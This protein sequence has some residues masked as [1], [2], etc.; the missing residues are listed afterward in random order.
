MVA[1]GIFGLLWW[2]HRGRPAR[3]A[4]AWTAA[5][6]I[7]IAPLL[8][9]PVFW[10]H[11]RRRAVLVNLGLLAG[12]M[13]L[14][15]AF[16][17]ADLGYFWERTL[18]PR[19]ALAANLAG[20]LGILTRSAGVS[21]MLSV[22]FL[23]GCLGLTWFRRQAS[24]HHLVGLWTTAILLTYS[25][26]WNHH[27]LLALPLVVF[28][29]REEPRPIWLLLGAWLAVPVPNPVWTSLL[30]WPLRTWRLAEAVLFSIPLLLLFGAYVCRVGRGN[31]LESPGTGC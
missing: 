2:E 17:P 24:L 1:V 14:Y 22:L 30:H 18:A 19:P 12:S 31:R 28:L 10:V 26:T 25:R 29:L 7:K 15:F 21:R 13:A 5:T 8:F 20:A 27:H 16:H 4:A 9:A 6:Q 11:G 3:G 23:G